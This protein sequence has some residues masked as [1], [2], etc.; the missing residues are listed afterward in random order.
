MSAMVTIYETATPSFAT[1][2]ERWAAVVRRD[3][4]AD[5]LFYF[6]VQTTGIY[7]RPS[8]AARRARREHVQFH[9]TCDAAE[10]AGFRPCKRCRPTE[11][12]LVEQHAI[13][14]EKA[15]RL[16]EHAERRSACGSNQ[17]TNAQAEFFR[18]QTGPR[19]ASL[20]ASGMERS[21]ARSL[22]F[23]FRVSASVRSFSI[24][25]FGVALRALMAR[26]KMA[27]LNKV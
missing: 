26:F 9:T 22:F 21:D 6:A 1:D 3:R 4:S 5:D 14:V 8:C 27:A 20:G 15:C 11:A 23:C 25:S 16:I 17:K 2:E 13:A 18:S 19:R 10:Q 24:S 12:A 7:C